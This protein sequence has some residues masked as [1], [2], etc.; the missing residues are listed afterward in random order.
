MLN[1]P[2][3]RNARLISIITKSAKKI[4]SNT[5]ITQRF[6]DNIADV[7]TKHVSKELE[8]IE[9]DEESTERTIIAMLEIYISLL[10]NTVNVEKIIVDKYKVNR[11]II[12]PLKIEAT[13]AAHKAFD[14][15]DNKV[16]EDEEEAPGD[17]RDLMSSDMVR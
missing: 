14:R 3:I 10:K 11:V 2:I 7:I 16:D 5:E 6:A 12:D 17:Y 4:M 15:V 13:L 1:P 9:T 8:G